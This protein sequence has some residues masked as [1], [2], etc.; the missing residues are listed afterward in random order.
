MEKSRREELFTEYFKLIDM[1]QE[2][3]THF[4]SIKNWS[5]TLSG[6]A[7]GLAFVQ[8][9]LPSFVIGFFLSIGFWLTETRYK[10]LQLNHMRRVLDLEKALQENMDIPAASILHTFREQSNLNNKQKK[11]VSV[12]F[13]PQVMFPHLFF[14]LISAVAALVQ[15]FLYWK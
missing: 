6:A 7:L 15:I 2:Y 3:D 13:W 1:L 5:V 4:L 12:V 14:T 9:S 10:V 8:G 11:W